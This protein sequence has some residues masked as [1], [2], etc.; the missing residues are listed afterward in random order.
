MTQRA[1]LLHLTE[2]QD[3]Q[4]NKSKFQQ[5]KHLQISITDDTDNKGIHK[6]FLV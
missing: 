4:I 5:V 2:I 1:F 6:P 3:K